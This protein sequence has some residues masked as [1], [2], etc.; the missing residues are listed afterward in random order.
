MPGAPYIANGVGW[1]N[2]ERVLVAEPGA[3]DEDSPAPNDGLLRVLIVG[4]PDAQTLYRRALCIGYL[5]KSPGY[6][7]T[8]EQLGAVLGIS[9]Q[10]AAQWL[11]R[12]KALLP[13]IEQEIGREG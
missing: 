4:A 10:A 9:K 3:P 6:P 1:E 12:F 7:A 2:G 13:A 11:T 5:L 8:L